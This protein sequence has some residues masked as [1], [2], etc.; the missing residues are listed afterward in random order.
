V[1]S[2]WRA[3]QAGQRCAVSSASGAVSLFLLRFAN[4]CS[5]EIK[6]WLTNL[7]KDLLSLKYLRRIVAIQVQFDYGNVY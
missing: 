6:K 2:E 1:R 3:G 5:S 4:K 7:G